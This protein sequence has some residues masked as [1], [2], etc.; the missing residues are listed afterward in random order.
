M[1]LD[2]CPVLV[3]H[4]STQLGVAWIPS[5]LQI[6]RWKTVNEIPIPESSH[7]INVRIS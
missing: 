6:H 4:Y 1:W 7:I 3:D 5:S 2:R